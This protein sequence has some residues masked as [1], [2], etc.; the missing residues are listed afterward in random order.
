[1][2][3]TFSLMVGISKLLSSN[4]AEA[5]PLAESLS[6]NFL[7]SSDERARRRVQVRVLVG[8]YRAAQR[9]FSQPQ[10]RGKGVSR[11]G[12]AKTSDEEERMS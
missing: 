9:V 8:I 3:Q 10:T 5:G 12:I 1:M 6:P 7:W 11:T 2:R 4:T